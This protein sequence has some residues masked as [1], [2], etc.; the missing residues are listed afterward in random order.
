[1]LIIF[2][3]SHIEMTGPKRG[4][5]RE[6]C[7]LLEFDM[8]IKKGEQE[9]D[10]LQLIDGASIFSEMVKPFR[11]TRSRINGECGAVDITSALVDN[12]VEATIEV[13]ISKVQIG[14]SFSQLF[15]FYWWIT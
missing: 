8:R 4:I 15:C 14:F 6:S 11:V 9:E 5:S 2:Q 10:D 13:D 3:G 7:V 12:A 1:M